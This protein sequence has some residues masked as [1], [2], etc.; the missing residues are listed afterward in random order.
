MDEVYLGRPWRHYA[1]TVFINCILDE[2]ILPVG[3]NNWS[4]PEAEKTTYYAEYENSGPGFQPQ[5]QVQW[6]HQLK[7]NQAKNTGSKIF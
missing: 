2:Y 1:Q 5:Q 6:S 7:A 3:W 4:K